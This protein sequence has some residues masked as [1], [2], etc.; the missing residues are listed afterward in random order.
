MALLA[1]HELSNGTLTPWAV[2]EVLIEARDGEWRKGMGTAHRRQI[3]DGRQAVGRPVRRRPQRRRDRHQIPP[4]GQDRSP[5]GY[6][7]TERG[8]PTALD[9]PERADGESPVPGG[10]PTRVSAGGSHDG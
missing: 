7:L 2:A 4:S 8:R 3:R 5:V 1:K 9:T 6:P 10:L